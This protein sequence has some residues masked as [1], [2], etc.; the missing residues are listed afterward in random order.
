MRIVTELHLRTRRAVLTAGGAALVGCATLGAITLGVANAQSTPTLM[1]TVSTAGNA[2]YV[3]LDSAQL[4]E[5]RDRFMNT[6]AARLGVA[7]DR[8]QQALKDTEKEVGPVPLLIGD[9]KPA[10][11]VQGAAISITSD[12]A[13]A[14]G[15]IGISEDQLKRELAGKSLTDVARAHTVDPQKVASA[16]KTVRTADLDQAVQS[17][18]L[19]ADV[20][21]TIKAHLDQEVDM[22]MNAVRSA[23]GAFGAA[24]GQAIRIMLNPAPGQ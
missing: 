11:G 7:S 10:L 8:L 6:L 17:G 1:S 15:A 13:P 23:D 20:A 16:V 22:L 18:K 12:L 2:T 9:G 14:A 4:K 21:N 5:Q 19:P 24:G 3:S